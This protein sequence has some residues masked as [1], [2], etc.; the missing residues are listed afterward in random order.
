[1]ADTEDTLDAIVEEI[2]AAFSPLTDAFESH[3]RFARFMALLGWRLDALI[4]A[5]QDLGPLLAQNAD[6]TEQSAE[7][8]ADSASS[9]GQLGQ[10][11]TAVRA[12]GS[13]S[14]AGLP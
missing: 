4:P 6:S 10:L 8:T 2:G 14:N 11:F 7:G 1:M 13:M 3:A 12:L 9:M 5:V